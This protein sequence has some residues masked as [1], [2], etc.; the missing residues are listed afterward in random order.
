MQFTV[1]KLILIKV[2]KG[3]KDDSIIWL[4]FSQIQFGI[5]RHICYVPGVVPGT[6]DVKIIDY[7]KDS[8]KE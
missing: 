1:H 6:E 3:G 4:N 5:F 2:D 8:V 7:D